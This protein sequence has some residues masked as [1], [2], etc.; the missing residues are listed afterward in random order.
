MDHVISLGITWA[1]Q[2]YVTG[3]TL[4]CV[5]KNI[6]SG[7]RKYLLHVSSTIMLYCLT[8][9]Y[10]HTYLEFYA[11]CSHNEHLFREGHTGAQTAS[12]F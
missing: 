5:H 4:H 11:Q 3:F 10:I 12:H 9:V 8:D 6:I 2:S 1:G 7:L